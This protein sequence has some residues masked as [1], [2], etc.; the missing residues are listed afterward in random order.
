[1]N[2]HSI[3]R[4]SFLQGVGVALALPMLESRARGAQPQR[5]RRI[6]AIG[7]HLGFY[8]PTFFPKAAGV[9]APLSAGRY[10]SVSSRA[11]CSKRPSS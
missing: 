11:S 3:D 10:Q 9:P 7:N 8:P 2:L 5:P 6:L 4:R 1:M